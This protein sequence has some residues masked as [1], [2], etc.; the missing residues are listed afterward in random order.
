MSLA[1]GFDPSREYDLERFFEMSVDLL[2]IAGTDGYFR[3][4]NCAFERALGWTTPQLLGRPFL[5]LVHPDDRDATVREVGRLASGIPTTSF[6]NRY[7]CADGTYKPLLWTAFPEKERG[8]L[9]AVARDMTEGRRREAVTRHLANAVEQTADTVVITD[10]SGV[11]QYVNPAFEQTTG[12]AAAEVLGQTPRILK[13]GEHSPG[14]YKQLWATLLSGD[15]FR[16]I[17]INRK[18]SGERYYAEQTITPMKDALGRITHFVSVVKDITE[19]RRRE[20]QDAELHLAASIQRRLYPKEMPRV[21][22]YDLAAAT[23]PANALNGDYFDFV[24][25]KDGTLGIVIGD[26]CGHGLGQALLMAETRAFLRSK[27]CEQS[28]P[29]MILTGLDRLLASDLESGCFVSLMLIRLDP[30]AR[31]FQYANAGHEAGYLLDRSGAVRTALKST[32][33]PLGIPLEIAPAR[34]VG[35]SDPMP[36]ERGDVLTLLTDGAVEAESPAGAHFG[37]ER[38]MEVLGAHVGTTARGMVDGLSGAIRRFREGAPQRD[39]I[40]TVVCKC[41]PPATG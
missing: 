30:A 11:I 33:F 27:A 4:V 17:V 12:Y 20:E 2:C 41:E 31:T 1:T 37:R 3:R 22:G 25:L 10:R 26:V 28:D 34:T 35:T 13:S 9:Y 38:I 36:L 21:A 5:D 15:V 16:S 24:T 8:L 14:F 6:E 23:A 18:K 32:G 19:R 40:T 39:D 29:G 7:R